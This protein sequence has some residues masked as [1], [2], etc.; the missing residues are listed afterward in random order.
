MGFKKSIWQG[1]R[2]EEKLGEEEANRRR[3]DDINYHSPKIDID[4]MVYGGHIVWKKASNYLDR[5]YL[6]YTDAETSRDATSTVHNIDLTSNISKPYI[7]P[8]G[9]LLT[10]HLNILARAQKVK[11]LTNLKGYNFYSLAYNTTC[12]QDD[13]MTMHFIR[14]QSTASD[15]NTLGDTIIHQAI[16]PVTY[17]NNIPYITWQSQMYF[18]DMTTEVQNYYVSSYLF[19]TG[20]LL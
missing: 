18:T 9:V 13:L 4:A 11:P 1:G 12:G 15:S 16:V 20:F 8:N 17:D 19:V 5:I 2:F 14:S 7:N 10:S 3:G 6:N